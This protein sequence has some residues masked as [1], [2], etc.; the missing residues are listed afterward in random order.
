MKI[1][2][3]FFWQLLRV[4]NEWI[5]PKKDILKKNRK[6]M[7][8]K[9]NSF[10]AI[11]QFKNTSDCIKIDPPGP[12]RNLKKNQK[13]SK[14]YPKIE[15]FFFAIKKC[16]FCE[17]FRARPLRGAPGRAPPPVCRAEILKKFR[18]K[19]VPE[20]YTLFFHKNHVFGNFTHQIALGPI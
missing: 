10:F 11:Y 3:I 7:S 14:K 12:G 15:V 18:G 2:Q 9:R 16:F 19:N 13:L 6:K 8:K 5:G 20:N 17:K 4:G 1:S